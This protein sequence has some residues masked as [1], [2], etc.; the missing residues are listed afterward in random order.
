MLDLLE[1]LLC[2]TYQQVQKGLRG[3]QENV[4]IVVR[5]HGHH[6]QTLAG[7]EDTVKRAW[8]EM[9][10]E[11]FKGETKKAELTNWTANNAAREIK[12]GRVMQARRDASRKR[13]RGDYG[14]D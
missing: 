10:R 14:K 6:W 11:N 3:T 8:K 5:V 2:M 9:K 12:R 13:S 4:R 1:E 7:K